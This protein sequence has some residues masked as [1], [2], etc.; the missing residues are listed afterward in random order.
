MEGDKV[1][2]EDQLMKYHIKA[3]RK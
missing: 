2:T 1:T 3:S